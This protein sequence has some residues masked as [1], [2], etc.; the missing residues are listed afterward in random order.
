[1]LESLSWQGVDSLVGYLCKIV[2]KKT[3]SHYLYKVIIEDDEVYVK[4][5]YGRDEQDAIANYKSG[6]YKFIENSVP[7]SA[8]DIIP[9]RK[10]F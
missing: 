4:G 3:P 7:K 8:Y 5:S 10:I 9:I 1:M 2:S 6:R